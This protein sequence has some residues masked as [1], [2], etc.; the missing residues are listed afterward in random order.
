M[1]GRKSGLIQKAK[2]GLQHIAAASPLAGGSDSDVTLQQLA[3]AMGR[4]VGVDAGAMSMGAVADGAGDVGLSM[5]GEVV[6]D[7][8]IGRS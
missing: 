5:H 7:G 6:A 4:T 8:L 1:G 3:R 2:N